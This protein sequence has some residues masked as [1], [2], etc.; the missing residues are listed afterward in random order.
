[1]SAEIRRRRGLGT[2]TSKKESQI[3]ASLV[4]LAGACLRRSALPTI[5]NSR[6]LFWATVG[7]EPYRSRLSRWR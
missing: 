2:G 7:S 3:A 5:P 4:R 6:L 1:M